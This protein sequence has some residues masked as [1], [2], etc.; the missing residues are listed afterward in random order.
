MYHNCKDPCRQRADSSCLV[1]DSALR[2][3]NPI[4]SLLVLNGSA[5]FSLSQDWKMTSSLQPQCK[6]ES[7]LL[8]KSEMPDAA[9]DLV[10]EGI[11]HSFQAVRASRARGIIWCRGGRDGP[12]EGCAWRAQGKA[13]A[14]TP[15]SPNQG[16]WCLTERGF[17][18]SSHFLLIRPR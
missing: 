17:Y 6:Q 13:D 3:I 8:E 1:G 7:I 11:D 15:A 16:A 14:S 12:E 4:S 9:C 2:R 10:Q 5:H 18:T